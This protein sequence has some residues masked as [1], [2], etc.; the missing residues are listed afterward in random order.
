MSK[1]TVAS[2]RYDG[3]ALADHE[4]DVQNLGPA[5]IALGEL[6]K[7]ANQRINGDRAS[8][9]VVVNADV[10]RQCFQL[11]F[12]VV[13]TLLA[14]TRDF[15]EHKDVKTAKEI[16]EWIGI[17][18]MAGGSVWWLYKVL[19]N[20]R[21]SGQ[22][23]QV[24]EGKGVV[25]IQVA[26]DDNVIEVRP[27]VYRLATDPGVLRSTQAILRPLEK[28]G[29]ETL[30]FRT[31][32]KANETFTRDEAAAIRE[33]TP[34]SLAPAPGENVSEI[35]TTVGIHSAVYE[36]K[37]QWALIYKRVI[38]AAID[39]EEWLNDF[40]NNRVHA[41]PNWRLRVKLEERWPVDETGMAVGKPT[42]RVLKVIDVVRPPEQLDLES[43]TKPGK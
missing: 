9:R 19:A 11:S 13:Q 14:A 31:G 22:T 8:V 28:E 30:E 10:E 21:K 37:A 42:Y 12:E 18:G 43:F 5:L 2:I 17:A 26:G 23:I 20:K 41:P 4:M 35:E 36:G 1:R 16:L 32:G 3:P 34:D 29:Y 39:D 15:L 33:T 6:C 24:K 25:I 27:E 7:S 40:Q 38:A